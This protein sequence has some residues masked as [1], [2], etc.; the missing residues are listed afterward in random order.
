MDHFVILGL[1]CFRLAFIMLREYINTFR[2][3]IE[4]VLSGRPRALAL[5]RAFVR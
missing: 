5:S 1:F 3:E 2:L 4:Q